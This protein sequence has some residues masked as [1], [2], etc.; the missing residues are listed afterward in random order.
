M[1]LKNKFSKLSLKEAPQIPKTL[2]NS[3][4]KNLFD[5]LIVDVRTEDEKRILYEPPEEL[6][7]K[8]LKVLLD[9]RIKQIPFE[10]PNLLLETEEGRNHILNLFRKG[11]LITNFLWPRVH[12]LRGQQ[13]IGECY[14]NLLEWETN[15]F[16]TFIENVIKGGFNDLI[17]ELITDDNFE[18]IFVYKSIYYLEWN[19]FI[20]LIRDHHFEISPEKLIPNFPPHN[21]NVFHILSNW[22]FENSEFQTKIFSQKDFKRKVASVGK[23]I[24]YF[25]KKGFNINHYNCYGMSPLDSAIEHKRG[26]WYIQLLL[27]GGANPQKREIDDISSVESCRFDSNKSIDYLSPL[28]RLTRGYGVDEYIRILKLLENS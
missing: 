8:E 22:E 27:Q 18:E 11:K 4:G 13:F 28:Q 9:R 16:S 7:E 23:F 25:N 15:T 12:P 26:M 20:S 21:G 1:S 2:N 24:S 5:S 14:Y 3:Q 17:K 6:T 10:N 19:I